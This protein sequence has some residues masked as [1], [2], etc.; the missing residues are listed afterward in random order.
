MRFQ[1]SMNK[2]KKN[3]GLPSVCGSFVGGLLRQRWITPEATSWEEERE[4]EMVG[5]KEGRWKE[6]E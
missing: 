3:A 6:R 1:S 4:R 5:R 2:R